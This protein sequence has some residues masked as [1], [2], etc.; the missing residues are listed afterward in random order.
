MEEVGVAQKVTSVWVM[1][2]LMVG[3]KVTETVGEIVDESEGVMVTEGV[4]Q[5]VTSVWVTV[6]VTELLGDTVCVTETL[7]EELNDCP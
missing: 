5:K 4:D 3:V 1:L 2:G 7:P 6:W